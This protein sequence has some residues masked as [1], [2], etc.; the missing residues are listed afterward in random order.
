[1]EAVYGALAGALFGA[2]GV[3][4][5]MGLDRGGDA[6]G[7]A[8][9]AATVGALA[10]LVLAV[11]S[12]GDVVAAELWP[13]ALAGAFVPGVSSIVM[14][15][16]IRLTGASRALVVIG[17]A[18]LLSVLLALLL[19]DE[20]FVFEIALGTVLVVG[21]GIL[22]AGETRPEHVRVLGGVLALVCAAMFAGRDNLVRWAAREEHPPPLVATATS[23]AFAA[24]AAAAW[25]LVVRRSTIRARLA[26]GRTAFVAAGL[27]LALAYAALLTGLDT[28]RVSIVAPLNATQSLWGVVFAALL[29]RRTEVIGRRVVFAAMLVVAGGALIAAVR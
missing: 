23:L 7:G 18:P 26:E 12:G 25:L 29:L 2:M 24:A 16:A 8:A 10:G 4:L 20:P 28:G 21:A 1:V 13:F 9:I 15:H 17:V 27:C 19:L 14:F 11:V 22:L 5:R 3:V 6:E